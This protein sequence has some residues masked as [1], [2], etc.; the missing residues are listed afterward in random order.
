MVDSVTKRGK[1]YYVCQE[2][3]FAYETRE[4]AQKCEEW[5]TKHHSCSLEITKH[6]VNISQ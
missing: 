3:G 6:A 1:S 4:L 5:C 2:C